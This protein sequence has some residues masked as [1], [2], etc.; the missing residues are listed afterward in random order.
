MV[1]KEVQKER[2]VEQIVK[3]LT[4]TFGKAKAPFGRAARSKEAGPNRAYVLETEFAY[5]LNEI[6]AGPPCM[7]QKNIVDCNE[8]IDRVISEAAQLQ[9]DSKG[10]Q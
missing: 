2:D 1:E 5:I 3:Y 8:L 4:T 7:L 6:T 10:E 9:S